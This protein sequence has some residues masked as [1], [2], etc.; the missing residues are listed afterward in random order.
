MFRNILL[1]LLQR[2]IRHKIS[3]EQQILHTPPRRRAPDTWPPSL[4]HSCHRFWQSKHDEQKLVRVGDRLRPTLCSSEAHAGGRC[5]PE[6][7]CGSLC[8]RLVS[9]VARRLGKKEAI[10]GRHRW[11]A[12][13]VLR[14]VVE[15]PTRHGEV[16]RGRKNAATIMVASTRLDADKTLQRSAHSE[17]NPRGEF[18]MVAC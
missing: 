11:S 18:R 14:D 4:V 7:S 17:K 3:G 16:M 6:G 2:L 5:L 8:K 12:G 1:P 13:V 10:T 9:V 15:G